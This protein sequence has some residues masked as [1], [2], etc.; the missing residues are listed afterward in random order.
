MTSLDAY[1][2]LV[3]ITGTISADRQTHYAI[4]KALVLL[5]PKPEVVEA[6]KPPVN[7][8]KDSA[9]IPYSPSNPKPAEEKK[10]EATPAVKKD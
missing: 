2:F 4:E 5:K 1:E 6:P 7:L 3:K 10:P 8:E 9:G